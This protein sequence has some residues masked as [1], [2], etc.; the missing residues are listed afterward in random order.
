MEATYLSLA[1]ECGIAVPE[2]SIIELGDK[3][4]L[5]VKRFDQEP[6]RGGLIGLGTVTNLFSLRCITWWSV[7]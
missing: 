2:T 6:T 7:R 1:G 3:K 5:L 4:I